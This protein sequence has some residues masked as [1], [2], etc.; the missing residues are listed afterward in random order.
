M[1]PIQYGNE[2]IELFVPEV[3]QIAPVV[4]SGLNSK[5]DTTATDFR[6]FYPVSLQHH[7]KAFPWVVELEL[8]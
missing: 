6:H 1:R 2:E 7:L 8:N 3:G 5:D 4:A